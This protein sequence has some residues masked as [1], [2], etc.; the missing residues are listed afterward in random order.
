MPALAQLKLQLLYCRA[1][2]SDS[3]QAL[4]HLTHLELSPFDRSGAAMIGSLAGSLRSLS[5]R[6]QQP[7]VWQQV[8][9]QTVPQQ[10][11]AMAAAGAARLTRLAGGRLAT[12]RLL[13]LCE[14]LF[15]GLIT[16]H[17]LD[18]RVNGR[19]PPDPYA[20]PGW[21]SSTCTSLPLPLPSTCTPFTLPVSPSRR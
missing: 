13:L 17:G 14:L 9:A 11:A 6:L 12:L 2:A 5:V 7:P 8:V 4:Q 1:H 16:Q 20:Q 15:D 10:V 19:L 21:P 18:P 3:W